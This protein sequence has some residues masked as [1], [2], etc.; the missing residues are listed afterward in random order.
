LT[1]VTIDP[2][3]EFGKQL[4]KYMSHFGLISADIARLIDST[5]I[6]GVKK[7]QNGKKGIVLKS[8]ERI[9]NIFG[10]RYFELGNPKHHLPRFEDLPLVTQDAIAKR[11]ESGITETSRN[12][13]LHLP[14]HVRDALNHKQLASEFTS[15]DVMEILPKNVQQQ[16]KSIQIT[17]IFNNDEFKALVEDTGKK[18]KIEGKRGPSQIIYRLK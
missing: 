10:L 8:A 14:K 18:K 5:N 11:K 1:Q 13:D 15:A 9:A 2:S 3:I 17:H 16:I 6:E 4:E 12:K 7:I